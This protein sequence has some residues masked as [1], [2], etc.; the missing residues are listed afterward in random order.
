MATCPVL[1]GE[2]RRAALCHRS[3]WRTPWAGHRGLQ[4]GWSSLLLQ[5]PAHW[6]LRQCLWY[7]ASP[8][9]QI[10]TLRPELNLSL[11]TWCPHQ[12]GKVRLSTQ[13]PS[14]AREPAGATTDLPVHTLNTSLTPSQTYSLHSRSHSAR[15]PVVSSHILLFIC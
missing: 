11:A 9:A 4:G 2:G 5:P 12:G 10:E 1:N 7:G 14:S 13:S 6:P 15:L 8:R 3:A